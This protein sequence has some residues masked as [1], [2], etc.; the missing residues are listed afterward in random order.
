MKHKRYP[1]WHRSGLGRLPKQVKRIEVGR[2][3]IA[4]QFMFAGVWY[5]GDDPEFPL[6]ERAYMKWK[7]RENL[8]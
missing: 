8:A 7:R 4:E 6:D 5:P 1:P 3:R 2:R